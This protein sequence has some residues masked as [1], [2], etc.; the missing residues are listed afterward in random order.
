MGLTD[1]LEQLVERRADIA[2]AYEEDMF[3]WSS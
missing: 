1:G 3:N 2:A